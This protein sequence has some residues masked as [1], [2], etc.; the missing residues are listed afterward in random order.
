[1]LTL[2]TIL[3]PIDF[4]KHSRVALD[5]ALSLAEQVEGQV[6]VMHVAEHPEPYATSALVFAVPEPDRTLSDFLE[7]Q[8]R[9]SMTEFLGNLSEEIRT[10]LVVRH[11]LGYPAQVITDVAKSEG[12]AAI[13]MGTHGRTGLRR[14]LM[15]SVAEK[16]VRTSMVPVIVIPHAETE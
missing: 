7:R 5:W 2:K 15:G 8:A 9:E 4:S 3:V 10:R 1:M 6:T 16:V 13:V 11:D 12:F 14:A